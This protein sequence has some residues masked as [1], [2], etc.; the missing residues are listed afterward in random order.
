MRLCDPTR[1]R[2]VAYARLASRSDFKR[3]ITLGLEFDKMVTGRLLL[4][5]LLCAGVTAVYGQEM[6]PT[7]HPQQQQPIMPVE[8]DNNVPLYRIQV[9]GRDIPAIN[10]WH[11]SGSTKVGFA[12]TSLLPQG[13]GEANVTSKG[14]TFIN[15]KL[16]GFV[17][18]NSFGVEYLTYVLWAIT[19]QGRPVNLGEVMPG[20]GKA[21]MNVT[22]N[23][24][25]FALIV[26]AE[27]YFA[28]TTPSDLVVMQ[29]T[30][31]KDKTTGIIDT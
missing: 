4:V 9:V 6:S 31:T 15:A 16:Q 30:V 19:P 24:Q 29:N 17:P 21:E 18:A 13:K 8:T 22:T 14:Q 2:R 11:R 10:Y 23:L 12:G 27:P 1:V 3:V 28:V 7:A 26:T 20:N 25:Q 5:T